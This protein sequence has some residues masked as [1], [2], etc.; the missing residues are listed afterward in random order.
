MLA[1]GAALLVVYEVGPF[2]KKRPDKEFADLKV[3]SSSGSPLRAAHE[4][5]DGA[6]RRISDDAAWAAWLAETR[7]DVDDWMAKRRDRV[8][9]VAGW[10]HDFVSP[11]DGSFLTWTPEEPGPATLS[12][13]SDSRIGLTPRLHAAWVFGF[14]SRHTTKVLEAARLGRLTGE[15]KYKDWAAAQLDFYAENWAKWPLQ[16]AK[17]K[18]RLMHQSLDDANVLVRLVNA[19]RLLDVSQERR[20]HWITNLFR[21]QAELLDST[22][23]SIHNIACWQRSAM[24]QAAIYAEDHELW[25]RAVN[26]AFGV[27]KQIEHGITS[28]YLWFEQSLSYNSY[29]VSAFLPL[30][31]LASLEGRAG[32]LEQEMLAVENLML[33]PIALR[34]LTGQTPNPADATGGLPHAPNTRMLASA[35]RVFPTRLGLSEAVRERSWDTLIDPP[36][37]AEPGTLPSVEPRD[38]SSSRMAVLR[39][40]DWQVYVHYGQLHRSHAQAEALNFEAFY[41]TTDITHD[42]GTVGY[43]SPLHTGFYRTGLAHNVPLVDGQG[44][45]GWHSGELLRFA[46]NRIE[47]RQPKYRPDASAERQMQIEGDRLMDRTTIRINI[48]SAAPRRLGLVLHLQGSIGVPRGAVAKTSTLPYWTNTKTL[49]GG[50][51]VSFPVTFH[52]HAMRVTLTASAP[53]EITFGSTPDAPPARRESISVET[54]GTSATFTTIIEPEPAPPPAHAR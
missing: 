13:P 20:R 5:W 15:Q 7:I 35:Y 1:F 37:P 52:D 17:S 29:V 38:W 41:R 46:P 3:F 36:E 49:N 31:T 32:E 34:F 48:P 25:N 18:A 53:M 6:R 4:D 24:A 27:R 22:F 11:K 8:E 40:G 23:Q 39:G 28:D 51:R 10:W 43:G 12:S 21:P 19:A 47:V 42:P 2:L 9:W 44:Q 14:R 26:G 50:N 33:S 30:F 45:V 16:T 54:V